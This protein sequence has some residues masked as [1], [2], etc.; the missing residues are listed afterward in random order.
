M[1]GREIY[2]MLEQQRTKEHRFVKWWRKENDFLDYDLIDRF[3]ANADT[4]EEIDGFD[5]LTMDEMWDAVK[6]IAGPRIRLVHE[7]KA[8]LVEWEHAGKNGR[9]REVCI[10]TP[11]TVMHIFDVETRG[12][13]ICS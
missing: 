5:L 13:P 7:A 9:H 6:R 12:N 2:S 10:Y 1:R 8:D 3:V 4:S 11:E